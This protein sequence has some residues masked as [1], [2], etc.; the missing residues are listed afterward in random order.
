MKIFYLKNLFIN[1][2]FIYNLKIL[3]LFIF[4]N[5]ILK[6]IIYYS[7]SFYLKFTKFSNRNIH[8]STSNPFLFYFNQL[9][10]LPTS[11]KYHYLNLPKSFFPPRPTPQIS[12]SIN[13]ISI[14]SPSKFLQN[15]KE[16]I[17][18]LAPTSRMKRSLLTV[19]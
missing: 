1:L 15:S 14:S 11:L 16:I 17:R 3:S 13:S 9:Q 2:F 7:F 6:K 5:E 8:N 12:S 4:L 18:L 19:I 10:T